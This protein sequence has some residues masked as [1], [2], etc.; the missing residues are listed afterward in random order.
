MV[1]RPSGS[2]TVRHLCANWCTNRAIGV[3][4]QTGA[5]QNPGAIL[6]RLDTVTTDLLCTPMDADVHL[7]HA[8]PIHERSTAGHHLENVTFPASVFWFRYEVIRKN[9]K[10][11]VH[12]E[13]AA[14]P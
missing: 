2:L 1:R 9:V 8:R 6:P 14:D 10:A 11:E 12:M 5:M 7:V 13:P 4:R 3:Q